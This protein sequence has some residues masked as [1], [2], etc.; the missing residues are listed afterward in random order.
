MDERSNGRHKEAHGENVNIAILGA[1]SIARTMAGTLAAMGSDDRYRMLIT[2]YAVASRDLSRAQAFA[3]QYGLKRAYGSYQ[4]LV[5]DPNVDLVYIATPHSLHAEQAKLCLQAGRNVL[6]EKS[7]AAN[8]AQTQEVLSLAEDAGLLCTEAIWTRYMPSRRI[9]SDVLDTGEI[10][11]VRAVTANLGYP[12]THKARIVDPGL[13]GGALLDVG[14]YPLNFIDMVLRGRSPQRIV[15][16]MTPYRTGV[17]A[18][19][20]TT[21]F[22]KNGVTAVAASSMLATSDR[23]GCVWGTHGY[24]V[25]RNIN[26]IESIDVYNDDHQLT[27]HRDIPGQL[28]GYEYEVAAAAKAIRRGE[29]ECP[30]MPHADTLRVMRLM[31]RIRAAWG[32]RFPFER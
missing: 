32:L 31:D 12:M 16:A 14:V 3:A 24:V 4:E 28:T 10:G 15:T 21:L 11:E 23:I 2:P 26:N 8:A 22:Y 13:A 29:V 7:F 25:C 17:D 20:S 30:Q 5:D 6:V 9:L 1:G 27:D 18:Q 19:S